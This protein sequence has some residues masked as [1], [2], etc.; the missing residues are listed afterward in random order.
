MSY[1]MVSSRG[2]IQLEGPALLTRHIK[3]DEA[4]PVPV[5]VPVPVPFPVPI[6]ARWTRHFSGLDLKNTEYLLLMHTQ[7]AE[8]T[9]ILPN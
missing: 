2:S 6:P 5:P 1:R 7:R 3:G 9:P 4:I 8:E